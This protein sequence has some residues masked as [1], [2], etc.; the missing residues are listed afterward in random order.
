MV[1]DQYGRSIEH[2]SLPSNGSNSAPTPKLCGVYILWERIYMRYPLFFF[3]L[4]FQHSH[5]QKKK[6]KSLAYKKKL[7][8]KKK[9]KKFLFDIKGLFDKKFLIMLFKCWENM[10]RWNKKKKKV[11]FD[12]K[13]SFVKKFLVL[14]FKCCGNM[15]GWKNVVEIC[16]L[17]FK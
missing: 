16:V 1:L 15:C 2:P 13:G 11:L 17:L 9:K 6:K 8:N 7:I 4:F 12:I 10:C 3:F 14:L 5:P